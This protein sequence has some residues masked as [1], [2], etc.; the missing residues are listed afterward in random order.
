MKKI[1]NIWNGKVRESIIN[2]LD[3]QNLFTEK[4]LRERE[5]S[6]KE[7]SLYKKGYGRLIKY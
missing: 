3:P 5:A 7:I 4:V 6:P 1:T 2:D